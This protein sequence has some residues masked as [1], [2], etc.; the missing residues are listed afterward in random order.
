MT[1]HPD[2][3]YI[4]IGKT[5]F[6]GG[7]IKDPVTGATVQ[8]PRV[9]TSE[10][11]G[12]LFQAPGVGEFLHTRQGMAFA[13]LFLIGLDPAVAEAQDFATYSK[14][15][16]E[17]I[18]QYKPYEDFLGAGENLKVRRQVDLFYAETWDPKMDQLLDGKSAPDY[19]SAAY[20][21]LI[22][23]RQEALSK[24]AHENPL[25][26][27]QNLQLQE[28]P[29]A[30]GT[31]R[32]DWPTDSG[33]DRPYA[34]AI[35]Q[36]RQAAEAPQ[37][38]NSPGFQALRDVIA[39]YDRVKGKMQ[40]QGYTDIFQ[41]SAAEDG[42]PEQLARGLGK[43]YKQ[44]P[45]IEQ[46]VE[47]AFGIRLD[48]GT[49]AYASPLAALPAEW[50][51]NVA[52]LPESVRTAVEKFDTHYKNLSPSKQP[53]D[54]DWQRNQQYQAQSNF[55][56]AKY[57]DHP[58]V[59]QAWWDNYMS[60]PQKAEYKA[61][62][63]TTPPV[64]YS[65]WDWHVLGKDLSADTV[66]TLQTIAERRITIARKEFQDPEGYSEGDAYKQ[67]NADVRGW[68]KTNKQLTGIVN[69]V[70]DPAWVL[71]QFKD[72][73]AN[74][75]GKAGEAWK[76]IAEG[77]SEMA[78]YNAKYGLTGTGDYDK[79]QANWYATLQKSFTKY[80]DGWKDYSPAFA[81]QWDELRNSLG[82]SPVQNL[83]IPDTF[84]PL[85]GDA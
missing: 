83:L 53:Y 19:T 32:Y 71:N 62:L 47:S 28:E 56:D 44:T 17:G 39:V 7:Q 34:L 78:A 82:G 29:F 4:P 79:G 9:P 81:S 45:E 24:I 6:S 84:F 68:M 3:S 70:N 60:K 54:Y 30:D 63:V 37:V 46:Y 48:N 65:A 85:G 73:Y 8:T 14:F 41:T 61:N 76:A 5:V 80:V 74:A 72:Q 11:F 21:N 38:R 49:L 42:L 13:G 40:S 52:N 57:L 2:L 26:A 22:A 10:F 31:P 58:E 33:P 27:S 35:D 15:L 59:V 77:A 18:I 75:P 55:S 23:D 36:A 43:V 16:R 50:R 20:K 51:A 12:K 69:V 25:W 66:G 64:F 67:L 1:Q